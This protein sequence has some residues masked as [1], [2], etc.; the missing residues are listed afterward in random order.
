MRTENRSLTG[1]QAG[2]LEVGDCM[3]D[4]VIVS[5]RFD[6]VSA[7]GTGKTFI[8]FSASTDSLMTLVARRSQSS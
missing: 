1:V 7:S 4:T 2:L 3:R 5:L 8:A 6:P